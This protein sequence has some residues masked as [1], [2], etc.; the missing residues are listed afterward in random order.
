MRSSAIHFAREE[1]TCGKDD[2]TALELD[3]HAR[4]Y[5]P[6]AA[7]GIRGI[8]EYL[9]G[10]ILPNIEVYGVFERASPLLRELALVA[11]RARAPHGGSLR[12]VEHAELDGGKVGDASRHAAQ[13]IDLPDDLTFGNASYGRIARHVGDLG[14]IHRQQQRARTHACCGRGGFAAGMSRT[15]DYDIVANRHFA[16][17]RACGST[18]SDSGSP[19]GASSRMP[20]RTCRAD[21]T[22]AAGREPPRAASR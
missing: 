22:G 11:L 3:A 15:D 8:E 7:T 17:R 1:R 16:G 21:R 12:A 20:R 4:F 10:G 19:C 5:A 9:R 18:I 14:H 13:S 6:Y 2:G